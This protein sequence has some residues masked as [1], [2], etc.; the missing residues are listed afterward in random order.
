M[1]ER[2]L[3][4]QRNLKLSFKNKPIRFS[5]FAFDNDIHGTTHIVNTFQSSTLHS[6]IS[7]A[8][9]AVTIYDSSR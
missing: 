1:N 5:T 7:R 2:K 8:I 3:L 4:L 6:S 9:F